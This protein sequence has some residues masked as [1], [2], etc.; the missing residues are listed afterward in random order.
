MQIIPELNTFKISGYKSSSPAYAVTPYIYK[1][2]TLFQIPTRIEDKIMPVD[3]YKLFQNYPNP[4]NPVTTITFSIPKNGEVEL[5]VYVVL[6]NEVA[7]LVNEYREAG[8]YKVEFNGS[9]LSSG[10]YFYTL[11][12]G[13]FIETKK[14]A[15]LK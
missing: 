8:S 9:N 11:S 1:L 12:A 14:L 10:I 5:K 4:F 6:G 15:I 3:N 2:D 13:S 7:T